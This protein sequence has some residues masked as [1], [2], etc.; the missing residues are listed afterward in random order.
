MPS[1][2]GAPEKERVLALPLARDTFTEMLPALE[3]VG[4]K[5]TLVG[6]WPL[7]VSVAVRAVDVLLV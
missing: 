2:A 3:P 7:T 6:V 1:R 5:E 4:G